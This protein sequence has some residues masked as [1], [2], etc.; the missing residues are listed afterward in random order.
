MIPLRDINPRSSTPFVVMAVIALNTLV[1]FY[2]VSLGQV[3]G[4]QFIFTLGLVPA[5]IDDIF[6]THAVSV[7]GALMPLVTSMFLHGGW[8]H[9]I[10]NM[11]FLWVFGDNVEDRFGHDKFFLFYVACGLGAGLIHTAFNWGS[12]VPTV[13]ASGAISGVMGA[14]FVMFPRSKIVTLVPLLVVFFTVQIPAMFFVGYWIVIQFVGGLSSMRT[15]A[16]G[17]VAFWAH[18]GGFA[19]GFILAKIMQPRRVAY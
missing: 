1:W 11:W 17:G 8:M 15:H 7:G 13:G 5:R 10:G 18:I 2:Q 19:I 6:T 4:E 9:V 3:A 16:Q 12:S 14:Y